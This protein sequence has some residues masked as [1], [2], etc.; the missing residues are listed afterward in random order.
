MLMT[1][2]R[3]IVYAVLLAAAVSLWLFTH[4]ERARIKRV[5][6]DIER[7]AAK[8][9]GESVMECAAKSRSLARHFKDG[10]SIAGLHHGLKTSCSRED[11]AGGLLAFRS[12]AMKIAVA[13]NELEISVGGAEARVEGWIDCS[14]TEATWSGHEP[15]AGKF[16]AYLEKIDGQWL[17]SRIKVP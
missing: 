10:C 7:L 9:P 6:A 11:I 3:A 13:F 15:K 16:L 1:V 4:S 5:F 8:E 12:G 2:R 17:I 14:G